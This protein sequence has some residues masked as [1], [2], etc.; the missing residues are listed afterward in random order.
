MIFETEELELPDGEIIFTYSYVDLLSEKYRAILQQEQRKR[1]RAQ[2]VYDI[3]Y[4]LKN[5]EIPDEALK[6]DILETLIK[7]SISRELWVP[8]NI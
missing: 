6:R 5:F 2:D 7:K 4:I 3:Y 8:L 1:S